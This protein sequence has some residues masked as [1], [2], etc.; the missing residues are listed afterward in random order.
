MASAALDDAKKTL[1]D[2]KLKI[3]SDGTVMGTQI[4]DQNGRKLQHVRGVEWS[5]RLAE[6]G[7]ILADAKLELVMVPLELTEGQH[8]EINLSTQTKIEALEHQ[9]RE[10]DR[11]IAELR[12]GRPA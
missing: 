12:A 1:E 9:N 5:L 11:I 2:L 8:F 10:K 7:K 6:N 4:V 3:I